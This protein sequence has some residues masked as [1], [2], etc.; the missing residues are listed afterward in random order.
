MDS[1][2]AQCVT[3][4]TTSCACAT[5][6]IAHSRPLHE[7][8]GFDACVRATQTSS[9]ELVLPSFRDPCPCVGQGAASGRRAWFSLEASAVL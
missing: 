5:Q 2:K 7:C 6:T 9:T 8:L 3:C 4:P 1:P